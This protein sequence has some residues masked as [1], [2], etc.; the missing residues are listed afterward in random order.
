MC[1][2]LLFKNW[3]IHSPSSYVDFHIHMHWEISRKWNVGLVSSG[4]VGWHTKSWWFL[5]KLLCHYWWY[6]SNIPENLFVILMC[7]SL[8]KSPSSHHH[9]SMAV[10]NLPILQLCA[11]R[12]TSFSAIKTPTVSDQRRQARVFPHLMMYTRHLDTFLK[13]IF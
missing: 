5:Q 8:S 10:E 4:S 6:Q 7:V 1:F 9:I 13:K 12:V 11:S 2:N 3:F